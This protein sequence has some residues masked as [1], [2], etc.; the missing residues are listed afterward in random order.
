[1][2]PK[3]VGGAPISPILGKI[4]KNDLPIFALLGRWKK[5]NLGGQITYIYISLIRG[6]IQKF[7]GPAR[8]RPMFLVG[9]EFPSFK[10]PSIEKCTYEKPSNKN[11]S[12]EKPSNNFPW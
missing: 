9:V 12:Y 1:M 11:I 3:I 2:G 10:K 7:F 5:W 4:K 8:F 6:K